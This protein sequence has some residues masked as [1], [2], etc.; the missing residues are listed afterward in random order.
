MDRQLILHS[1]N[2]QSISL[3]GFIHPAKVI[4]MQRWLPIFFVKGVTSVVNYLAL[5]LK[6]V[7]EKFEPAKVIHSISQ[8]HQPLTARDD[9]IS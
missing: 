6:F 4:Q 2:D 1:Y 7:W 3:S 9:V 8:G 5:W